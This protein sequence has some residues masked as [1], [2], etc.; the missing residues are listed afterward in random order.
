ME[1]I[2]EY[3]FKNKYLNS[4]FWQNKVFFI[5]VKENDNKITYTEVKKDGKN[6][7]TIIIDQKI[8]SIKE[9]KRL[10]KLAFSII[11]NIKKPDCLYTD[12]RLDFKSQS[13]ITISNKL[14]IKLKPI[15]I[16]IKNAL[17]VY[18]YF[19]FKELVEKQGYN[20]FYEQY[21]VAGVNETQNQVFKHARGKIEDYF[22]IVTLKNIIRIYKKE[23]D[24]KIDYN[25]PSFKDKMLF[26][27]LNNYFS[28]FAVIIYD[29]EKTKN[30]ISKYYVTEVQ[31]EDQ[32]RTFINNFLSFY[33]LIT[34]N[35]FSY[36]YNFKYNLKKCML[37]NNEKAKN[38][39]YRNFSN[40]FDDVMVNENNYDNFMFMLE[41]LDLN[42]HISDKKK[43][44]NYISILELL[45]VK[46]NNNISVQ[47]QAKCINLLKDNKYSQNEIKIAYDYRSKIIHGEYEAAI[48]KLHQL[49]LIN[50]YKFTKEELEYEIYLNFE[51]MVE[52]RL[53]ERLYV[54]LVVVLR[55]FIFKNH[56]II[57]LKQNIK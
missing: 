40:Y 6:V 9:D 43:I 13:I 25:N 49:S 22:Y 3:K 56:F 51:Q 11:E 5:K 38:I 39:K 18:N 20:T 48:D 12:M 29:Q 36:E 24:S 42:E 55:S 53:S 52:Q 54:I 7:I 34:N 50:E 45:L 2:K 35:S 44:I 46:G 17:I 1:E 57:Y 47:L 33:K 8:S 26:E 21:K 23:V 31:S 28:K 27:Y 32:I 14:C 37:F 41:I 30:F 16:K 19:K 10:R 4:F 15:D